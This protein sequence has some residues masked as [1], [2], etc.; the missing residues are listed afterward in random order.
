MAGARTIGEVCVLDEL[1]RG[2]H[3]WLASH[4]PLRPHGMSLTGV[5]HALQQPGFNSVANS[6]SRGALTVGFLEG[7]QS[8]EEYLRSLDPGVS[9]CIPSCERS[10]LHYSS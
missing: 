9:S 10:T 7:Q 1:P 5:H 2:E 6:P 3:P 8:P 4:G